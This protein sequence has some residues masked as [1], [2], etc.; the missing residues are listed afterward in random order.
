M[1]IELLVTTPCSICQQAQAVWERI[2]AEQNVPLH[3]IDVAHPEGE[4][5][6]TRLA[7]KTVPAVVVNGKLSG[8]GV[9]SKEDAE[10][11]IGTIGLRGE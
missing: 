6:M 3:V 5:L 2:A 4:A 11:I 9:P 7:L 8:I 1:R 10:R